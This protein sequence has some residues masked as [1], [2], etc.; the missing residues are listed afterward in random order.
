MNDPRVNTDYNELS[1]EEFRRRFREFL[2]AH[3]PTELRQDMRRP[4]YRLRGDDKNDWLKTVYQHGW[5]APAWPKEFGG[6]GLDFG[7]QL[8]YMEEVE[9][10]SVGRIIDNGEQMLGPTLMQFGSEEQKAYYLPRILSCEHIWA[11]G[12]SEP[13]S[14]SDL[15]S[16][17]T[18]AVR[19]GDHFVVNGQKIWTTQAMECTH[20]FA[21]V[22][23]SKLPKKQQGISFLLI[24]L[25][26]PGV[27]VRP[28]C[29][30]AGEEELCEVF[31][32][33]V[34]VPVENL[35]GEL[36]QGW[37][38]A[39]A[40]LGHERIFIGSPAQAIKAL[41][42]AKQLVKEA[43]LDQDAGV[44]D[45]LAVL[46]ADLHDYLLLYAEMCAQVKETGEPGPEVSAL[47]LIISELLQRITEF[48]V[49]VGQEYGGIVGDAVIG[50][51]TFDL[52]WPM[53]M[54]RPTT[55]FAG[56]SEVQ[57]DILAKAVLGMPSESKP[58]K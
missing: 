26:T 6:M 32:D 56:A 16:L 23:T 51:T 58:R 38:I 15:A 34:R 31:F 52:H 44:M 42:V 7:K 5:R 19:D 40:L 3:Y 18:Q 20:I 29:S 28:I 10:A 11:Q 33:N 21:L 22:R 48:N 8:I 30:I 37:T 39:K 1:D 53:M 43:A 41:A 46:A 55:I 50:G 36:D 9:R 47:K 2:A 57:R 49:E 27:T 45:R 4:F 35:V 13:G 24:D 25:K 54:A 17:R 12:Y 14:G